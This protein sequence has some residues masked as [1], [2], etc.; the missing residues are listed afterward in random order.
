MIAEKILLIKQSFDEEKQTNFSFPNGLYLKL[1]N[2]LD[3]LTI[4]LRMQRE[5]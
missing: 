5:S 1:L 2:S 3:A 4:L